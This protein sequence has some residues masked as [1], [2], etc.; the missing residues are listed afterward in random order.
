MADCLN[1]S[2]TS[3][4][5]FR[6]RPGVIRRTFLCSFE[7]CIVPCCSFLACVHLFEI[8]GFRTLPSFLSHALIIPVHRTLLVDSESLDLFVHP[9]HLHTLKKARLAALSFPVSS[10]ALEAR[11]GGRR[12]EIDIL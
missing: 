9:S 8:L 11:S 5:L 12:G 6:T 7:S 10:A 4:V 3:M 2:N 1:F